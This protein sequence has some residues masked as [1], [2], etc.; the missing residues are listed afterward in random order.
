MNPHNT[1]QAAKTSPASVLET[2]VTAGISC[3]ENGPDFLHV[4]AVNARAAVNPKE[5]QQ[6]GAIGDDPKAPEGNSES[7]SA[8]ESPK[9]EGKLFSEVLGMKKPKEKAAA[10]DDGEK[11]ARRK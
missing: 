2:P 3:D 5:E 11:E 1:R 7:S 10:N 4:T 6:G 8:P 9:K